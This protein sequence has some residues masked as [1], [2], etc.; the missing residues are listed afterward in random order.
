MDDAAASVLD[1]DLHAFDAD[2]VFSSFSIVQAQMLCH[3]S[4]RGVVLNGPDLSLEPLVG[5]RLTD[6]LAQPP[7]P[8]RAPFVAAGLRQLAS[9]IDACAARGLLLGTVHPDAIRVLQ[10]THTPHFLLTDLSALSAVDTVANNH[11]VNNSPPFLAPEI[12]EGRTMWTCKADVWSLGVVGLTLL[13]WCAPPPTQPFDAYAIQAEARAA[14]SPPWLPYAAAVNPRSRMS[15]GQV[16]ALLEPTPMPSPAA[17]R[18]PC[19][20]FQAALDNALGDNPDSQQSGWRAIA[21]LDAQRPEVANQWRLMG[22]P[23]LC[24]AYHNYIPLRNRCLVV[25]SITTL[26]RAQAA[27]PFLPKDPS[28]RTATYLAPFLEYATLLDPPTLSALLGLYTHHVRPSAEMQHLLR[29]VQVQT[30]QSHPEGEALRAENTRL[31]EIHATI[32]TALHTQANSQG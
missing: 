10:S 5:D 14:G 27:A 11:I 16:L 1:T 19:P 18:H 15:A 26:L 20:E 3:P 29:G 13:R 8:A 21:A 17:P 23:L 4:I 32:M 7:P 31:R 9:A 12:S 2:S 6:L 25:E 24:H 28:A 22:P 30:A